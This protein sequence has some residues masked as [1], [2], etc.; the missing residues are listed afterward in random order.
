MS[1]ENIEARLKRLEDN[2]GSIAQFIENSQ[3][4]G[5]SSEEEGGVSVKD[6]LEDMTES[7]IE[8][9]SNRDLIKVISKQFQ[10]AI[11]QIDQ[12][13]NEGLSE[14]RDDFSKEQIAR[15]LKG[16]MKDH[17]EIKY[18]KDEFKAVFQQSPG[19]PVED[20]YNLITVKYPDSVEAARGKV[21]E[22]SGEGKSKEGEGEKKE[23][24][25]EGEEDSGK[26]GS[27][28]ATGKEKEGQDQKGDE[29]GSDDKAAKPSGGGMTPSGSGGGSGAAGGSAEGKSSMR[30]A[31]EQAWSEV[32]GS[33]ELV[34]PS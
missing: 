23:G 25:G 4:G 15:D 12:R 32:F 24:Q 16:L 11:Q 17:P 20:V 22:D 3:P 29:T 8:G 6:P 34:G 2:V 14:T 28:E 9:L 26:Q 31:G 5:K 1:G 18:L 13:L 10:G 27:G 7:E 21:K 30:E 19:L 33:Q